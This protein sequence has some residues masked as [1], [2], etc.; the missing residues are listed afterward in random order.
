MSLSNLDDESRSSYQQPSKST[1]LLF[2]DKKNNELIQLMESEEY[3]GLVQ[4]ETDDDHSDLDFYE[5]HIRIDTKIPLWYE[6]PDFQ[7]LFMI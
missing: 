6:D 3:D 7:K 5:S 4:A 2:S 1:I